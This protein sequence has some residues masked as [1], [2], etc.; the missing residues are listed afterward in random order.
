MNSGYHFQP[1]AQ[2]CWWGMLVGWSYRHATTKGKSTIIG[3]W[4]HAAGEILK[5]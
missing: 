3:V 4:G 5:I 2:I 1:S